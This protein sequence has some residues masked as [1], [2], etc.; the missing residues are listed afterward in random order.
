M[1]PYPRTVHATDTV[2]SALQQF[3]GL[4]VRHLPVVDET[5]RLIGMLSERDLLGALG[6]EGTPIDVI[7]RTFERKISGL[8]TTDIVAADPDTQVAELID[9]MVARKIGAVPIID[10]MRV[11][12][13]IVS[14]VDILRAVRGLVADDAPH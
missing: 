10:P 11:V 2:A 4:D 1:T 14:Y 6:P 8:M 7:D 9:V 12:V 3:A 13:G 5:D